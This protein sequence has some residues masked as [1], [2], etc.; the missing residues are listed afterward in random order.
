MFEKRYEKVETLS[1]QS[2]SQKISSNKIDLISIDAE[3]YD[4][5]ILSQID[6]NKHQTKMVIVETDNSQYTNDQFDAI[7]SSQDFKL[8]NSTIVNRIYTKQ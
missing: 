3:G 8:Y 1:F 7:F 5:R 4:L 2:L 6:L